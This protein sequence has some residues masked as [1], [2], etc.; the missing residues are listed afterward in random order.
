MRRGAAVSAIGH[1]G[2]SDESHSPD[3][4]ASVVVRR[5]KRGGARAGRP[6]ADRRFCRRRIGLKPQALLFEVEEINFGAAF[7]ADDLPN[8]LRTERIRGHEQPDG[9]LS[10]PQCAHAIASHVGN[11]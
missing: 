1:T 7:G 5:N 8:K 11:W 4:W 2:H 10:F 6:T 3:A 9:M